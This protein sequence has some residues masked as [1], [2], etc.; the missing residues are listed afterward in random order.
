[1]KIVTYISK[2]RFGE[3]EGIAKSGSI[4]TVVDII[5]DPKAKEELCRR[6]NTIWNLI[7]DVEIKC[8]KLGKW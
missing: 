4:K 3:P 1:M 7:H 6:E 8:I 2:C 5:F